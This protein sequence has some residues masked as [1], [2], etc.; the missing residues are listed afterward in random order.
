MPRSCYTDSCDFIRSLAG[1]DENGT[2]LSRSD[3]SKMREE[4]AKAIG[5]DN[6]ELAERLADYYNKNVVQITQSSVANFI[7]RKCD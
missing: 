7:A 4:I 5:M 2:K 6:A 3:A 1:Y